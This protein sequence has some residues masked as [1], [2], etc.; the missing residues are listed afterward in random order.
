MGAG[1]PAERW[2]VKLHVCQL[3]HCYA[4]AA[5]SVGRDVAFAGM[6][7][8][9]VRQARGREPAWCPGLLPRS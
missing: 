9:V 3:A 2:N 4:V 6:A 7:F 1:E 8:A 5:G